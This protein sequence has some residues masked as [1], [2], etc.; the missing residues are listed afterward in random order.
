M[1]F[2]FF[3]IV[4]ILSFFG[5]FIVFA[6]GAWFI[7]N[8]NKSN[9]EFRYYLLHFYFKVFAGLGFGLVYILYYERHG[10]TVFYWQG[11]EKLKALL[12]ENPSAY[13]HELF[14]TPIRNGVPTYFR[15]VGSPPT[16]IYNEPN[17][18]FVCKLASF[19]SLFTFGSY[20]TLNLFFSV[21]SSWI[22]WRFYR[23]M[24]KMLEIKPLYIA[25]ACLFVPS[26]AFWC[27]GIIKDTVALCSI[28]LLI[29]NLFKLI[30]RDY[31]SLLGTIVIIIISSYFLIAIRP[32]LLLACY[33]PIFILLVFKLNSQKPFIVKNLTRFV[34]ISFSITALVLY[35]RSDA[36][37][38]E[39]SANSVFETAEVIQKDMMNNAGYTGKRYNLGITE[40]NSTSLI[41]VIPAA[42]NVSLFRPYIWEADN[43]FMLLNG[44]ENF[45][46]LLLTLSL[47]RRRKDR[48]PLSTD[49]KNYILFSLI[50]V[51]I[52]GYFVGL[53]SGLFGT[54]VRFKAPIMPFFL[55]FVFHRMTE[56]R[57]PKNSLE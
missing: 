45:F 4:D 53:T 7:F 27:S 56:N 37:F 5:W 23:Y 43:P 44:I 24:N 46:I 25:I 8:K 34:G 10:D 12:F 47:F 17:S 29:M 15:N 6:M 14:S 9:P 51:F 41:T 20:L 39:F 31:T 26:V 52:L 35:F 40:F 22:T 54:L 48:T 19:L 1:M 16:W 21:I 11:A 30:R 36:A 57:S 3:G 28:L 42:L 18:W 50:F 55:L 2:D 13:F 33:L 38:G 32:F 49:L